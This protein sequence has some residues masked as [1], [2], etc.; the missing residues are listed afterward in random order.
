MR[1][2][3]KVLNTA[4]RAVDSAHDT[5]MKYVAP[6]DNITTMIEKLNHFRDQLQLKKNTKLNN[7][8]FVESARD[9]LMKYV[10]SDDDITAMIERLNQ[11][12]DQLQLKWN[13]TYNDLDWALNIINRETYIYH[14]N[15]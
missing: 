8:D 10:A 9:A 15:K 5:L 13:T 14:N 4:I 3:V 6:D 1:S 2:Q 7:L 11:I 12:Q